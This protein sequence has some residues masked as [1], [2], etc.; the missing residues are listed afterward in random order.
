M[1]STTP[2]SSKP[3]RP[4][5]PRPRPHITSRQEDGYSLDL[6]HSSPVTTRMLQL[7]ELLARLIGDRRHCSGRPSPSRVSSSF[8]TLGLTQSRTTRP[9]APAES[10]RKNRY[11]LPGNVSRNTEASLFFTSWPTQPGSRDGRYSM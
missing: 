1:L 10:W 5:L 3:P 9:S 6:S 11:H 2:R 4:R 8:L 7:S